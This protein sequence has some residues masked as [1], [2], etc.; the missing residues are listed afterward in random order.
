MKFWL[1]YLF[2][3][4]SHDGY[5]SDPE[6]F[7]VESNNE[8]KTKWRLFE[9]KDDLINENT[10]IFRNSR[11]LFSSYLPEELVNVVLKYHSINYLIISDPLTDAYYFHAMSEDNK[12]QFEN[13]YDVWVPIIPYSNL[14]E[15]IAELKKTPVVTDP[16]YLSFFDFQDSCG[17]G[18]GYCGTRTNQTAIAIT[19]NPPDDNQI[20]S[21]ND[22]MYNYMN[23]V[24]HEVSDTV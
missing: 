19:L 14:I 2:S 22:N 20:W 17:L 21:K 4:T 13:I 1:Q 5:C 11:H 15:L 3:G 23:K 7:E 9:I 6:C 18:S 16:Y 24:I 12:N 8:Y 10:E